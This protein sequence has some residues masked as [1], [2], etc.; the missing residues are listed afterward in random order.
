MYH[1]DL[2]LVKEVKINFVFVG[3]YYN[4]PT[5]TDVNVNVDP[6]GGGR[7]GSIYEKL[8]GCPLNGCPRNGCDGY[9]KLE[10]GSLYC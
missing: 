3:N 4:L 9:S 8:N 10:E 1:I 7:G 6:G 2:N 5:A